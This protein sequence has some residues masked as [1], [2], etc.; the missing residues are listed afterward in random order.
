MSDSFDSVVARLNN[1]VQGLVSLAEMQAR[2]EGCPHKERFEAS[3]AAY[4]YGVAEL[5]DIHA[6]ECEARKKAEE[7]RDAKWD[8]PTATDY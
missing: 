3:L 7:E 1:D 8:P 2:S 5:R 4:R 6:K